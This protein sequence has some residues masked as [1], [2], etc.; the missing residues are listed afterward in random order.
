VLF[1]AI[2]AETCT[3]RLRPDIPVAELATRPGAQ[4]KRSPSTPPPPPPPPNDPPDAEFEL[5]CQE[6]RCAFVDRSRD[7]DGSVVSWGWDFGDGAT[8][9]ERNPTH[10]Y[11]AAG[12]YEVLLVVTDDDGAADTRV[13][14]AEPEAAPSEPNKPPQADFDIHCNGLTCTFED[15]SKDDDGTIVSWSWSFGDGSTSSERNPLHTYAAPGKYDVLLTVTDDREA[16]NTKVR[17]ADAKDE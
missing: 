6:L 11:Q 13:H 8:S 4:P 1:R 12:R 7:E 10:V 3:L 15:K 5:D 14:T 9:S 17:E 2:A 16:T